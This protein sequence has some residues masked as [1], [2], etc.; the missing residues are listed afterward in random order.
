MLRSSQLTRNDPV[1]HTFHQHPVHVDDTIRT[2]A[3]SLSDT[4]GER[5]DIVVDL[6]FGTSDG[7]HDLSIQ[8]MVRIDEILYIGDID[9]LPFL[10][11]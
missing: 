4:E 10:D 1:I 6:L 8:F 11:Q 7:I 2:D 5:T 9:V 3:L